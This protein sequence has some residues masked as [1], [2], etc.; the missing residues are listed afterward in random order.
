MI[1]FQPGFEQAALKLKN[2]LRGHATVV[3]SGNVSDRSDVRLVLGK[4]AATYMA[5]IE[6]VPAETQL[7]MNEQLN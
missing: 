7:A 4:D 2:A 3:S 6:G 5:Q 1:Q